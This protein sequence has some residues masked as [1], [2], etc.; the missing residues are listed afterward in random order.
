MNKAFLVAILFLFSTLQLISQIKYSYVEDRKFLDPTD[1]LG[2]NFRPNKLEIKDES[3]QELPEGSYS[4]GITQNNLYV[5]GNDIKG[6]YNINNINPTEFGYQLLLM[7]ARDP[8]IQGH[9]KIILNA[10]KQVA[11]LIFRRTQKEKEM[12]FELPEL[13][14]HLDKQE[15]DFFTDR[16]ELMIVDKDSLWGKS[17]HPFL[18]IHLDQNI[19][20]R[21]QIADSTS[22]QFIEVV[23]IIDK[24]KKKNKK[25]EEVLDSLSADV[26]TL[27]MDST[28]IK[29]NQKIIKEHFVKIR[30]ILKY[31]DGTSEDKT[32]EF[33]IK[34]IDWKE[35]AKAID[36]RYQIS[37]QGSK[38]EEI[39]IYLTD[40]KKVS[41]IEAIDKVFLMRGY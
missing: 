26:D 33:P 37:L 4:F 17:I 36:D 18:R 32:W 24:T 7:N 9:L 1:L 14:E 19:Q 38:G 22:I 27:V 29:K 39:F 31:D 25:K 16:N 35:D 23:T 3:E 40:K 12:I 20:E 13:S 28:T 41:Y 8:R 2:Y 6:V 11:A 5:D 34:N 15:S 10:K 21:L 30:S